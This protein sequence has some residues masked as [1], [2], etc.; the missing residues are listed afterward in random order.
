[1]CAQINMEYEKT[2]MINDK[3]DDVKHRNERK[4]TTKELLTALNG[5]KVLP[6]S[7]STWTE[8]VNGRSVPPS[9]CSF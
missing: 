9:R 5:T 7:G 8:T 6:H 2:L 4:G 1:M 3:N